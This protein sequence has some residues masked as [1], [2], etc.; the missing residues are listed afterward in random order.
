VRS[1]TKLRYRAADQKPVRAITK[2]P[3]KETGAAMKALT[4]LLM[5]GAFAFAGAAGAGEPAKIAG[6]DPSLARAEASFH[7]FAEEWM[8]KMDAAEAHARKQAAGGAYRGYADDFKVELK[9]TGSTA[10]PYVGLLRYQEHQCAAGGGS[11]CK[12]TGTTAV[13]EIFRFQGGRWVY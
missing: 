1:V 9:P 4:R 5:V 11:T 13:T 6:S 10:A 2:E 7:D 8:N 12:V 3:A